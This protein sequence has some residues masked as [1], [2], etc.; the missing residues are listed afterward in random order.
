M[1]GLRLAWATVPTALG[2]RAARRDVA[3]RL[4]RGLLA[5]RGYPDAVLSNPCPRCGRAHG[6]VQVSGAPW[7]AAVAYA[8]TLAIVGVYPDATLGFA[9]DAEPLVDPVR[10]AAG[11]VPG[12]LLRWVRVEAVL[13]ADGRGLRVDPET[14][15]LT[16]RVGGWTGRIP[17]TVGT[18]DGWEPEGPPGMLVSAAIRPGPGV[19]AVTGHPPRR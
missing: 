16:E 9:I 19:P 8:G 18:I 13:K 1:D 6:P 14:V 7:R 11:G 10:D 5:E 2:G 15:D 17:G 4:A 3:W 12:G